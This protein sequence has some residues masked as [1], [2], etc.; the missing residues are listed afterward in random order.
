LVDELDADCELLVTS[1]ELL[2]FTV[3]DELV[4]E[5]DELFCVDD[6]EL[7]ADDVDDPPD[8]ELELLDKLDAD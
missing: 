3:D 1:V 4:E 7:E 8:E 5:L 6:E 2:L